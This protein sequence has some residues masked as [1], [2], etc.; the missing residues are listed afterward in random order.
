MDTDTQ[1]LWKQIMNNKDRGRITKTA[2]AAQHKN[3]HNIYK[4]LNI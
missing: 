1:L 4:L 3:S 2:E